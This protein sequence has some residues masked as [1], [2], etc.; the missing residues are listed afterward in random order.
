MKL[1]LFSWN[2]LFFFFLLQ[3]YFSKQKTATNIICRIAR[4]LHYMHAKGVLHRD[5]KPENLLL[6]TPGTHTH[7][8]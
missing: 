8:Q 5:L 4:A 2:T 1:F 6:R 3:K 7:K